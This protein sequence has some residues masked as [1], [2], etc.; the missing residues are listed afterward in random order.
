[1]PATLQDRADAAGDRRSREDRRRPARAAHRFDRDGV[2][3]RRRR[4]VRDRARRRRRP[5]RRSS[6]RFSERF[7]CRDVQHPVRAAAAAAVLVQQPVRRVPDLPRLRQHHRARH[8]PGRARS[9]E[10]DPAERH[11]AVEQAA[12]PRA[13]RRAEARGAKA[14]ACASTSRGRSSTDDEKRFVIEG[15]GGE[16][17]RGQGLLPLA[18]AQEIQGAR[19]RV[20][21]PLP[22]LPDLPGVR[23][24]AAA[25]RGARRPVGGRTIDVVCGADRARRRPL[26]RRRSRCRRRTRRSPTR[27][28]ARSASGSGSCATSASTT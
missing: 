18:R 2:H 22:R 3:R 4:G 20:P 23:R 11:R 19:P 9:V 14:A 24:R 1:M 28:C 27:C 5:A 10:V 21:E 13:A 12:L 16:L 6:H 8:G 7:E 26:L 25:A 17:R 15:D